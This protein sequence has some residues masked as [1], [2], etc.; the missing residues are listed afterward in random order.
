[1]DFFIQLIE[2]VGWWGGGRLGFS[3]KILETLRA[4]SRTQI[5]VKNE[6]CVVHSMLDLDLKNGVIPLKS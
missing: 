2:R 5:I 3:L 1:M 6:P 4:R